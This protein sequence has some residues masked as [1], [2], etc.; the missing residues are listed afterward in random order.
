MTNS[1]QLEMLRKI[2]LDVGHGGNVDNETLERVRG[3][4]TTTRP[5]N[6][7]MKGGYADP[8]MLPP[9]EESVESILDVSDL[10]FDETRDDLAHSRDGLKRRSEGGGVPA[11]NRAKRRKSR[12][13]GA[14]GVAQEVSI[15]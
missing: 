11:Q 12:S 13:L 10:S 4:D 5:R 2:L 8:R 6:S 9:V 1:F 15:T 3:I 14:L 7:P